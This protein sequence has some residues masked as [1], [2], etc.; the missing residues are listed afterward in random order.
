[1][2]SE[3]D[4]QWQPS[5]FEIG[6]KLGE[7]RFAKVYIARH[8]STK[9]IVAVK[10]M[11]CDVLSSQKDLRSQI[12]REMEVQ[13]HC[14]SPHIIRLYGWYSDE[15]R[16]YLVLEYASGG[17]LFQQIR[18]RG[19]IP[20]TEAAQYAHHLAQSLVYLHERHISHRDI[21]PENLLLHNN[22]LK[23]ADFTCA[24]YSP[25]L[26]RRS[27]MCGTLDYIAPE[28]ISQTECDPSTM[29]MWSCGVVI[30]EMIVG[31]APFDSGDVKD[32]CS[33]IQTADYHLPATVS[34]LA[35]DCI[36]S[37]LQKDT[38]HR[39]TAIELLEHPWILY[40]VPRE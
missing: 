20:E 24:V 6:R 40:N 37:L 16:I 31:K 15:E 35:A 14:R 2:A 38:R 5:D 26:L 13:H 23:L 12:R 21:K 22:V 34:Q 39:L 4:K 7:G 1:M 33:L 32:T 11:S 25:N 28:L 29:D 18:S 3:F 19:P 30:Y 27:T 36:R 8:R 10:V 17:N 9:R